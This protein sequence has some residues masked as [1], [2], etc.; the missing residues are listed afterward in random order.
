MKKIFEKY[1]ILQYVV[2]SYVIYLLCSL[3]LFSVLYIVLELTGVY[4]RLET[5]L[6]LK[7]NSLFVLVP[8]YAFIGLSILCAF[9]GCLMYFYKYKR[10]RTRGT[11]HKSFSKILAGETIVLKSDGD[12]ENKA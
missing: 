1:L 8:L 11:F 4:S 9:I 10:S 5:A 12:T 7:Y 2:R 6:D 3:V